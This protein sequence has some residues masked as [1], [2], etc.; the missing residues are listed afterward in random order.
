M[1][2]INV[3]PTLDIHPELHLPHNEFHFAESTAGCGCCGCW[4]VKPKKTKEYYIQHDNT[5]VPLRKMKGSHK[6]ENRHKA[7]RRLR[8]IVRHKFDEEVI[9]Y[10]CAKSFKEWVKGRKLTKG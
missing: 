9:C 5:F 4:K 6:H 3:Q 2:V 7:N 1:S 10:D 8:H